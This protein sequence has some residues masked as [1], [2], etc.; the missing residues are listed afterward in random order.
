MG[1]AFLVFHQPFPIEFKN[2]WYASISF[3]IGSFLNVAYKDGS[4]SPK[5]SPLAPNLLPKSAISGAQLLKSYSSKSSSFSNV[6][7]VPTLSGG[8]RLAMATAPAPT[9]SRSTIF[10]WGSNRYPY[11]PST[12]STAKSEP[13]LPITGLA[14]A[15]TPPPPLM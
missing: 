5:S 4:H 14:T 2:F 7:K 8:Q 12:K 1:F 9:P 10:T 13:S 11:P 6:C 3:L 15:P